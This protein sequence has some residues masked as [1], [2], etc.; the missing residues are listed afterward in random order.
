MANESVCVFCGQKPGPFRA[1]TVQCGNTWQVACKACE[2]E[3]KDLPEVEICQRALVR[4]LAENPGNLRAR[5]AV[6]TGAED[7][8]PKCSACGEK[9]KF[10]REQSLDNSP[11]RDSIFQYSFDV[12]PA[13]CP[14]CGK[15]ELYNPRIV[16]QNKY[17]AHL[18]WKD[19]QG[20]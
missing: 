17:L 5:I 19:T 12:L 16:R 18:I 9:L 7:H 6:I 10:M 13:Y 20:K 11:A 14:A 1:T 15:Y 2:K 3:V 8:R 4:G